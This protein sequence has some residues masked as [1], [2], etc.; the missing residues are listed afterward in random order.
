LGTLPI[1]RRLWVL[2]LAIVSACA[3]ATAATGGGEAACSEKPLL[4]KVHASWCTS[5]KVLA[6]TWS[7]VEADLGGRATIVVFDVS[8]RTA[9]EQ[10]QAE[11]RRLGIDEF[12]REFRKQTGTI[13]VLDCETREPVVVLRGERDYAKY[14]E[15]VDKAAH[16]S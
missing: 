16:S 6:A 1:R 10:S 3:V 14:V 12:F 13:V 11:A 5:C 15:A 2:T 8:D 4:V 7:R 9:Y